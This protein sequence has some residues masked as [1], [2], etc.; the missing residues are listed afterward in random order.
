VEKKGRI[1]KAISTSKAMKP[2]QDAHFRRSNDP[3]G[4]PFKEV[5]GAAASI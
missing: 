2:Y 4:D 1:A 3:G 5:Q